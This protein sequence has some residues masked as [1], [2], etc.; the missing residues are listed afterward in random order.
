M[1]ISRKVFQR[2]END[3]MPREV[4]KSYGSFKSI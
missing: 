2:S 1:K 3:D 4:E